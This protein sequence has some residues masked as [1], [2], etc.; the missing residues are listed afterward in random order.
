[1][2]KLYDAK[3]VH[4]FGELEHMRE[5]AQLYV[6][7]IHS[8][9]GHLQYL[10]EVLDNTCDEASIADREIV[11]DVIFIKTPTSY[12]VIAR[13]N[14]R[15]VP[16][17]ANTRA[18]TQPR[19]SGKHR[20]AYD[21]TAG[22][23]GLGIKATA[24][25]AK[26]FAGLSTREEGCA[27]V[28]MQ[29]LNITKSLVDKR[30]TGLTPT[31]TTVFYEV[32]DKIKLPYTQITGEVI[33]ALI[34]M[35]RFVASF[36]SNLRVNIYLSDDVVPDELFEKPIRKVR[37]ALLTWPT[38]KLVTTILPSTPK[39]LLF[40]T[41]KI[42]SKEVWELSIF[43]Q[44]ETPLGYDIQLYLPKDME[45]G[46]RRE[47]IL[48]AINRKPLHAVDNHHISVVL[49]LVKERLAKQITDV[50]IRA[51][52]LDKYRLPI[53][54]VVN[55]AYSEARFLEQTKQTF[56]DLDFCVLYRKLL[57][58]KLKRVPDQLWLDLHEQ[59]LENIEL[60]YYQ[61]THTAAPS[62]GKNV[63]VL[64]AKF[65]AYKPCTN[66]NPADRELLIVEGSSAGGNVIQVRDTSNQAVFLLGGK[67]SSTFR[68][69]DHKLMQNE[70]I[71]DLL[72]VIG[73]HLG[74]SDL[75]KFQ[76]SRIVLMTDADAD[77]RHITTLLIPLFHKICP[78]LLHSGRIL[79]ATPPLYKFKNGSTSL[80][81][82]D[83]QAMLDVKIYGIYSQVYDLFIRD[84]HT[85]RVFRL[86]SADFRSLCRTVTRIGAQIETVA[87]RLVIEP[88]FL[89]L[90]V[91]CVDFLDPKQ[92]NC[93]AI[94]KILK[95]EQVTFEPI[96]G[97]LI[98]TSQALDVTIPIANLQKSIRQDILPMLN[99]TH[100]NCYDILRLTKTIQGS[101]NYTISF[102]H[103]YREF[104][105]LD[106]QFEIRR[107]KG[108]G[109]MGAEDLA[110]VV[111]NPKTRAAISICSPGDLRKM[112]AMLDKDTAVRKTL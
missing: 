80:Y 62:N 91:H 27:L 96:T 101:V 99:E 13:D 97:A 24:A 35:C 2:A 50:D 73:M 43:R 19:T 74:S 106:Q 14:A 83:E 55:V 71:S 44:Y 72:I 6:G 15:G 9:Y 17:E 18:F 110:T 7:D 49:D 5:I 54:G 25:M 48:G 103:L 37:E 3:S 64:L 38:S 100:W 45:I 102:Y 111:V 68:S 60:R 109:E 65:D 108:L 88:A 104:G 8:I 58:E 1:M 85:E 26:T 22:V 33:P 86:D 41:F 87:N 90:M 11:F 84:R 52:F 70:V 92:P 21:A 53:Y 79:V 107:Y 36:L 23:N 10:I 81:M 98:L 16:L 56:K 94:R 61:S 39:E 47:N 31:G 42:N 66:T 95:V 30:I 34:S 20:G 4:T 78:M 112:F 32:I 69:S 89:E 57:I 77:G 75:S 67:S 28:V 29:D 63:G 46:N 82:R 40:N 51:F 105:V 59:L 12:Q 76:F 93:E